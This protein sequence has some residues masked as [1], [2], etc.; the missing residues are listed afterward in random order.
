MHMHVFRYDIQYRVWEVFAEV[1]QEDLYKYALVINISDVKVKKKVYTLT[2]KI[3]ETRAVSVYQPFN[4]FGSVLVFFC[5]CSLA[6]L[7]VE[8]HKN[9]FCGIEPRQNRYRVRNGNGS[10]LNYFASQSKLSFL[11]QL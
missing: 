9:P 11:H 2:C 7:N 6:T 3:I 5:S 10:S 1:K 4:G 8:I